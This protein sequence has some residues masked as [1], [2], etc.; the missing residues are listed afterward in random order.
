MQ[1]RLIASIAGGVAG[2]CLASRLQGALGGSAILAYTAA[3]LGGIALAY[4]ASMLFD[5]FVGTV[6]PG[7]GGD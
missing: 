4:V 2:M 3:T 1:R 5:V 6:P 7:S